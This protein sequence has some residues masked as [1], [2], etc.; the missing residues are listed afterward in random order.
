MSDPGGAGAPGQ[1]RCSGA[2]QI[3]IAYARVG[4]AGKQA[5][6]PYGETGAD[7]SNAI[8]PIKRFENLPA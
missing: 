5:F 2:S 8:Y 6:E 7:M 4:D 3:Y 1:L